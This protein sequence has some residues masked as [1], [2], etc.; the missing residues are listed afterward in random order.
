MSLSVLNGVA[1]RTIKPHMQLASSTPIPDGLLS[2]N[3]LL[4]EHR[5]MGSRVRI[6]RQ[7]RVSTKLIAR[8]AINL[9][10]SQ[11][12]NRWAMPHRQR[13]Q[14]RIPESLLRR[15]MPNLCQ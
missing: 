4:S 6:L 10:G 3:V 12:L 1:R 15:G 14:L 13:T 2:V 8:A 9:R 7:I 11:Q 5:A